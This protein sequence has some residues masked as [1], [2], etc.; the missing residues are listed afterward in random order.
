MSRQP[1]KHLA[2][3]ATH[4]N[5]WSTDISMTAIIYLD[6]RSVSWIKLQNGFTPRGYARRQMVDRQ[7]SDR[8]KIPTTVPNK[9]KNFVILKVQKN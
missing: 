3:S 2:T 7:R 1:S 9:F 6:Y 5:K 8:L 4:I